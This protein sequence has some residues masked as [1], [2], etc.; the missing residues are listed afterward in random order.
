MFLGGSSFFSREDGSNLMTSHILEIDG[1]TF[2]K[3]HLLATGVGLGFR[4]R[5]RVRVRVGIR[6]SSANC[7]TCTK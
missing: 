4:V 7:F 6:V 5:A 2:M 3:L 1:S